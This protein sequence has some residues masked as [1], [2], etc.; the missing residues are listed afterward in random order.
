MKR[1]KENAEGERVLATGPLRSVWV[2]SSNL[3]KICGIA[4]YSHRRGRRCVLEFVMVMII[5]VTTTM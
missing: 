1:E 2:H 3:G 5:I 4:L